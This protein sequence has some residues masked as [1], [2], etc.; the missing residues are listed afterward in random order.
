MGAMYMMSLRHD[1]FGSYAGSCWRLLFVYALSPWMRKYRNRNGS[2]SDF[3]FAAN[4]LWTGRLPVD[5]TDPAE[6]EEH[7]LHKTSQRR[8]MQSKC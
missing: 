6:K 2:V 1:D 3:K 5:G 7:N 4:R 8:A